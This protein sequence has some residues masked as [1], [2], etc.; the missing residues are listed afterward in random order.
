MRLKPLQRKIG[1]MALAGMILVGIGAF[2]I[3][4]LFLV[5]GI[6]MISL[7]G[8]VA[9]SGTILSCENDAD[10]CA[11]VVSFRTASGKSITFQANTRSSTFASGE[12]VSVLYYPTHP[13]DAQIDPRPFFPTEA[14]FGGG[15]GLVLFLVGALLFLFAKNHPSV[16]LLHRYF[17]ALETQD[18]AAAWECLSS[19]MKILEGVPL[20]PDS[21]MQM[22]Q[23]LSRKLGAITEHK[24]T[25]GWSMI[26]NQA[27]F[28]VKV[29][30]G[31]NT[32]KVYP[33]VV[34]EGTR[35]KIL[36][37]DPFRVDLLH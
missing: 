18:Y 30:R 33:Y 21:F 36:R 13:H 14:L 25:G 4:I 3:V 1:P 11:P 8:T 16:E 31:E 10:G 26:A 35:W 5:I 28:T 6:Q 27:S 9:A 15:T 19:H 17:M 24:L 32:S 37:F 34:R 20:T 7:S 23:A 29:T 12:R 22:Q 2:L